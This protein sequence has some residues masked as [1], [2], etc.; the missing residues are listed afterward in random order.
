MIICFVIIVAVL[1]MFSL[2]SVSINLISINRVI[3]NTPKEIFESSIPLVM[4]EEFVPFFDKEL[5]N[6]KLTSYYDNTLS[7]YCKKYELNLYFYNPNDGSFCLSDRC[8][9]VEV[10]IEAEIYYI[11]HYERTIFYEIRSGA[12]GE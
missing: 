6:D 3:I 9:A 7:K 1:I 11:S 2:F 4:D 8:R 10:T 5:L 12:Y